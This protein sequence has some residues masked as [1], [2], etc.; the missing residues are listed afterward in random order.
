[1]N[2]VSSLSRYQTIKE[3]QIIISTL[4]RQVSTYQLKDAQDDVLNIGLYQR[5]VCTSI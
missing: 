1:M 4:R 2:I 3:Q 5:E